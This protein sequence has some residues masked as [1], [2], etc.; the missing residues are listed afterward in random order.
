[1][2]KN[3]E[4]GSSNTI[5]DGSNNEEGSANAHIFGASSA[6]K[7]W[8]TLT[9]LLAIYSIV[10]SYCVQLLVN[11]WMSSNNFC[12]VWKKDKNK[13]KS[14]SQ[15]PSWKKKFVKEKKKRNSPH[16]LTS[17]VVEK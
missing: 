16:N 5:G 13:N 4:S 11:S 1:M 17:D 14:Q 7:L 9:L 10:I 6:S 8:K 12:L 3:Q 2:N 15:P